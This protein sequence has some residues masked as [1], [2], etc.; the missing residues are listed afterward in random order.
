MFTPSRDQARRFFFDV[1][2]K[3]RAGQPLAGVERTALEVVLAHPEYH[4]LLEAPERHRDR[5]YPPEAGE[6]NPFLHL[7]LH[8]ALAEQLTIDQP[9]GLRERYQRLLARLGDTMHAQHASIDC[10]GETLWRAQ[11]DQSPVDEK[12]YLACLDRLLG[13]PDSRP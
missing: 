12:I 1:W 6:T 4:A 2:A 13:E 3:Y 9:R 10:L 8:L 5:D 7:S 11:R